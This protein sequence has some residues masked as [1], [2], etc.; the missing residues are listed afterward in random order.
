V[1]TR[2]EN[3]EKST[4]DRENT[5]ETPAK[6]PEFLRFKETYFKLKQKYGKEF[7]KFF[8]LEEDYL[9]PCSIF[10]KE[11]SSLE[12]VTKYLTENCGLR[13]SA[14]ATMFNRTNK[15]I[16]QAQK[17][18]SEKLPKRFSQISSKFWIP[19]SLFSE[20]K[21]SVL[22]NIITYMKTNYPLSF[23]QIAEIT[24]RD[25]TTVRTV[26]YRALAKRGKR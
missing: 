18:A 10:N 6:D 7:D 17:T 15:T 4:K 21:L 5:S 8:R 25:I 16:W 22:E 13:V 3:K 19:A 11:L 12:S 24:S 20:R 9:I 23:K 2:T 26:Y 14:I 1:A